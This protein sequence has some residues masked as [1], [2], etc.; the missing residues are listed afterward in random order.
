M[1]PF[2]FAGLALKPMMAL[3]MGGTLLL[4]GPTGGAAAGTF[5]VCPSGCPYAQ[6]GP[7]LA[8]A[9][10]GD[11]IRIAPG[12]YLGGITI[13]VS[14]K[15]IGAGAGKTIIK[16]GGPV[17]TIGAYRAT[18]QPTVSISGVTIT[19]GVSHSSPQSVDWVGQADVIATGGGVEIL[20]NADFSGGA[21]VAISDSVING[22]RAAPIS[23]LPIGP[24]CP[25]GPCSFAWAKGGGIDNWGA[26]TL[27]DTTVGDNTAAGPASDANGGGI[28][29][30]APSSLTMTGSRVSGN[31]AIAVVPD[32]RFAEG[33]GIFTDQG[34]A[35]TINDSVISDNTASLTSTLPFDVGGGNTL[36]MN[37]NGGGIHVGDGSSVRID[38]TV[39][40]S[41][42]VSVDDPNGEPY[43]FDSALHPGDGPL[44]L[45]NSTIADNRVVA[46]VGSSADVGTSGSAL[47]IGGPATVSNTRISTNTTVVTSE[48][49]DAQASAAV[50]AGDAASKPILISD[51]VISGNMTSASSRKGSAE[52]FGSG[53]LNDGLLVLR[54]SVLT[55]NVGVAHGPSGTARGGGIWNGSL[56][57]PAPAQ[58]TLAGTT[59]THNTL[60]GSA[61]I[62]IQG[63]GLFTVVAITLSGS[64]I[65]HNAPDDCYGC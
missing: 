4:V 59:V 50:Y 54:N 20:P 63:G 65:A 30:W 18:N 23:T 51:T 22:N 39:L 1:Q 40:R 2:K 47:D 62:T 10:G 53:L 57:N 24:A 31:R 61:G 28:N 33:G 49:G 6:I 46:R 29:D 25:T 19:G 41:N 35:L 21:T 13:D 11:T 9:R 55:D 52:V 16:G 45:R 36:D 14:V 48:A 42:L 32:G 58:L 5:N 44:V 64:R 37:A 60:S 27:V 17:V 38:N 7:A 3:A 34:S 12:T 43:A 26:L 15:L 56:Y 8:D